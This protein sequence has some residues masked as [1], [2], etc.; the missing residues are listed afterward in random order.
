MRVYKN[1]SYQ[2]RG[3]CW[4]PPSDPEQQFADEQFRDPQMQPD[5]FGPMPYGCQGFRNPYCVPYCYCKYPMYPCPVCPCPPPDHD[6]L[7]VEAFG[8]FAS[9]SDAATSTTGLIT[10]TNADSLNRNVTLQN[11]TDVR[12]TVPGLYRVVYSA[13]VQSNANGNLQLLRNSNLVTSSTIPVLT[14]L[15]QN[16]IFLNLSK[17]D[18]LSLNLTGTVTL[19]SGK[20]AS[21]LLQLI[22]RS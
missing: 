5:S 20:N 13:T 9:I 15:N 21:L 17:N 1:D 3:F 4:Q 10:F 2:G 12:I 18:V 8:Y 16:E 22:E 6:N 7:Q 11:G 19:S 14:G